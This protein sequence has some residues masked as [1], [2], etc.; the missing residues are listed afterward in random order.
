MKNKT[1]ETIETYDNIAYEYIEYSKRKGLLSNVQFKKEMEIL[2]NN[3]KAGS[4][5]LDVGTAIGNY[6]RY[7]TEICNKD[8]DVTGIDSSPRLIAFA[9]N[10]APKANFKVMD[11]RNL[12]YP[13]NSFDGIISLA[14]LIHVTDEDALKILDK[15]DM[16]LKPNGLFIISVMEYLDGDKE[17]YVKEPFNPRYN[18]YFNRYTKDFFKDWCYTKKYTVLQIIDNPVFNPNDIKAPGLTKNRF[19]IIARKEERG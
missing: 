1:D 17:L 16:M 14:T 8:F 9:R 15:F 13:E 7:L 18:T 3:L 5:I 12:D 11:M 2:V 10:N 4:K 6:P 19:S